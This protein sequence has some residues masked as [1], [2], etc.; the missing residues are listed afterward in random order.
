MKDD[1]FGW[2]MILVI[3]LITIFSGLIKLGVVK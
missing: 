2:L 3:L 1:D